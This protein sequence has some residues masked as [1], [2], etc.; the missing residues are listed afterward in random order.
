MQTTCK[1]FTITPTVSA[2]YNKDTHFQKTTAITPN[3]LPYGRPEEHCGKQSRKLSQSTKEKQTRYN[4]GFTWVKKQ[5]SWK[6]GNTTIIGHCYPNSQKKTAP[7]DTYL[8]P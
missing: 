1:K 8:Q 6:R 7:W 5:M 4:H 3:A 2:A